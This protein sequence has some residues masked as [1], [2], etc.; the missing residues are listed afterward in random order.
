MKTKNLLLTLALAPMMA[1]A[2]EVTSPNGNIVVNFMLD[3][4]GRPTYAMTYKGHDVILTSHL[5][6]ELAADKHASMGHNE[7][8][9]M[10]GFTI[11][12]EQTTT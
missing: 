9:L 12:D 10:D 3:N 7:H 4:T 1:I 6:L 2:T 5:G 8:H 11:T